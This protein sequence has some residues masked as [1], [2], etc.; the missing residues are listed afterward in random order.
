MRWYWWIVAVV[1]YGVFSWWIGVL[2]DESPVAVVLLTFGG[3]VYGFGLQVISTL[4]K[5]LR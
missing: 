2:T 5:E 3:V 4:R 1:P